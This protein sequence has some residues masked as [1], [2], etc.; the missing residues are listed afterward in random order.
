M[1]LVCFVISL[2]NGRF[3]KAHVELA[4]VLHSGL[5][6]K[7]FIKLKCLSIISIDEDKKG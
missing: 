1:I 4:I 5:K 3:I 6:G 2:H 7:T